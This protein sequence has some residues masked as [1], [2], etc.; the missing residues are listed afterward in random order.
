VPTGSRYEVDG[1]NVVVYSPDGKVMSTYRAHLRGAGGGLG[2]LLLNDPEAAKLY[3]AEEAAAKEA[4]EL[5]AKLRKA[6]EKEKAALTTD[7]MAALN[8]QFE[9]QQK[10]RALEV[11]K[12]EERLTKLKDTMKKR[13]TAKDTIVGRR[14]DEL[15]GVTDELGWEETGI[16]AS[17]GLRYVVPAIPGVVP[18]TPRA[19]TVPRQPQATGGNRVA[20]GRY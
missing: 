14:L 12:I 4:Q 11:S 8:K 19:V 2:G 13:E 20:S 18:A 9:A 6:E 7:L 16:P 15:T 3:A 17:A 10:R 1:Q 5:V